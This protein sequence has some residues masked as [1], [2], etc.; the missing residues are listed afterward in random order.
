MFREALAFNQDIGSWDVSNV[1]TMYQMYVLASAFDG[2][3]GTWNTSGVLN[4]QFMFWSAASFNQD[5][6]G[7]DLSSVSNIGFMLQYSGLDC[8]NYSNTLIGWNS[9]PITPNGLT[10]DADTL[11]YNSS[12]VSARNNLINN[13][14]WAISGDL[15]F[16]AQPSL[17]A[18]GF[19]KTG[20][21]YCE[22][23]PFYDLM[24]SDFKI[25]DIDENGNNVTYSNIIIDNI[26]NLTGGAGTFDNTAPTYYQSSNH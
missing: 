18:S 23:E 10:L 26:G 8:N 11:E 14:G 3:I 19:T 9:N 17:V 13:K 21:S 2:D 22:P 12:A 16:S 4:M 15:L 7:W 24:N 1:T 20:V 25:I 6:G 5:I